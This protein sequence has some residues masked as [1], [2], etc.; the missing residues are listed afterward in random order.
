MGCC[1][2]H[3]RI[4]R[5]LGKVNRSEP[6]R[7]NWMTKLR[8]PPPQNSNK[9][10][11]DSD[12][13]AAQGGSNEGVSTASCTY[14]NIKCTGIPNFC[15]QCTWAKL[16]GFA[17]IKSATNGASLPVF[18]FPFF[19]SSKSHVPSPSSIQDLQH[20]TIILATIFRCLATS[21]LLRTSKLGSS[22]GLRTMYAMSSCGSPPMLKNS[23]PF[24]STNDLK[25]GCVA[26]RT[27]CLQVD[28]RAWPRATKG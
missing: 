22:P 5:Q 28:F 18:G 27:R 8:T 13:L 24:C 23:R 15:P 11:K 21:P 12:N 25:M 26:T 19:T 7:T 6:N 10:E 3:P 4:E 9:E 16:G 1:P 17:T 20:P 2:W 14:V